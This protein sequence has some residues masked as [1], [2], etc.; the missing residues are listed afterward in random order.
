MNKRLAIGIDIGGTFIKGAVVDNEGIV[1]EKIIIPTYAKDDVQSIF[2]NIL[3]SIKLLLKNRNNIS[4]IG[5]G[6]PG[7]FDKHCGTI[8]G[9]YNIPSLVGFPIIQKIKEHFK[10]SI[11][12][13]NDATNAVKGE[14][15][16]GAGRKTD[17]LVMYTLG[18]GIGGG[19]I[20]NNR[21]FHGIT[22]QAGEVGHMILYP[23]GMLCTCGAYGC[24]EAYA[25]TNAM[26][27]Y[28]KQAVKRN[29]QTR[30]RNRNIDDIDGKVICQL[31]E[32][33]D[34]VCI[35]IINR[36]SS[37]IAIA[38]TSIINFLN[39]SLIVIGGGISQGSTLLFKAIYDNMYNLVLPRLRD[40]FAVVKAELGN[41][42]G[43]VGSAS[44]IFIEDVLY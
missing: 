22:N 38:S 20:L 13:D 10:H 35:D 42:A 29:L 4:G 24:F 8:E 15:L 44:S 9:C 34:L 33:N 31:A 23:N 39:I 30:L 5:I 14:F 11:F 16:F 12:I 17:S 40:S 36:I 1:L 26:I 19:I 3:K 21:V 25:S 37:Y 18:T 32:E 28:A 7:N 43:M 27:S 6:I 41:D 2:N